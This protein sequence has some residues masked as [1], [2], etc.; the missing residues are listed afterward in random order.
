MRTYKIVYAKNSIISCTTVEESVM[1]N[2][3]SYYEHEN[4]QLIFAIVKAENEKEA[5]RLGNNLIKE[6]SEKV[7]GTEY[8]L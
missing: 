5:A 2:G 4:G 1:L 7:W 3:L 8:I 6:V